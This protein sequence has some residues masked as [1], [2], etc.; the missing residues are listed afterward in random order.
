M[1]W[2]QRVWEMGDLDS[3]GKQLWYSRPVTPEDI[4][5]RRRCEQELADARTAPAARQQEQ[6]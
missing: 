5:R 1:F 2:P 4:L 3:D 6:K